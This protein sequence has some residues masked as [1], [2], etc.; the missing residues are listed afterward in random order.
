M[1]IIGGGRFAMVSGIVVVAIWLVSWAARPT[2]CDGTWPNTDAH[3]ILASQT[4]IRPWYG[5]HEVYGI[6][7]IPSEYD[8]ERYEMRLHVRGVDEPVTLGDIA[9]KSGDVHGVRIAARP[10]YYVA[11]AHLQTRVA[12]RLLITRHLS[13][14][15]T[16]C[17]WALVLTS[18]S[19]GR[20]VLLSR[21]H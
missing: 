20:K 9:D 19:Q 8:D 6:F 1:T 18:K 17:N 16:A 2:C 5:R 21:H 11:H 7:V 14:L 15:R 3:V 12:L 13:E 4:V 10:G